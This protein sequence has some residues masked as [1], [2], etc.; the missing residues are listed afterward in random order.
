MD[1][2]GYND[3]VDPDYS[4]DY[5]KIFVLFDPNADVEKMFS[6]FI[7]LNDIY[8]DDEYMSSDPSIHISNVYNTYGGIAYFNDADEFIKHIKSQE[9][10]TN[11]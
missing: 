2:S 4:D 7:K 11:D 1:G 6:D 9:E 3:T 10:Y 5:G 8:V